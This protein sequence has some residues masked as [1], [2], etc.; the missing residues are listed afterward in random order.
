MKYCYSYDEEGFTGDF[1]SHEEAKAEAAAEKDDKTFAYI[2]Q[3][4]PAKD[5]L[6]CHSKYI[7]EQ[8]Y[9]MLTDQ[10]YDEVGEAAECFTMTVDQ[11]KQLGRVI[12]DYVD[13]HFGFHCFGVDNVI[14]VDLE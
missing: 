3:A 6:Y 8:A 9:E 5:K 10:L 4:V 13:Q 12:I 2:G 14:R 11:Q 1:D 7:G